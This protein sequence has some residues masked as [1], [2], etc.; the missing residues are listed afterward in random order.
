MDESQVLVGWVVQIVVRVRDVAF[1]FLLRS[2]NEAV[3]LVP[4]GVHGQDVVVRR[5]GT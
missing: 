2:L 1:E 3:K 4:C 5:T